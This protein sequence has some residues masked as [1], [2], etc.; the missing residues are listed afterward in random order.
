MIEMTE[1]NIKKINTFRWVQLWGSHL[2]DNGY[3]TYDE[4]MVMSVSEL[5][6]RFKEV[7]K[8]L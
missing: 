1:E 4:I 2:L 8:P 7:T 5:E 3:N 6:K